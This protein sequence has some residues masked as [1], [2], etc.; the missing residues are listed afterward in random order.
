MPHIATSWLTPAAGAAAA[1][2]HAVH[3]RLP[4]GADAELMSRSLDAAVR[5]WWGGDATER[6]PRLW[7]E[8]VPVDR[9]SGDDRVRAEAGR[10]LHPRDEPFRAVL[11][12]FT[13]GQA[14]LVV[15]AHRERL[16]AESL[17][18]VAAVLTG[19]LS[20]DQVRPATPED[21]GE[22]HGATAEA[23]RAA[24]CAAGLEWATRDGSAGGGTGR[25][26]VE[27]AAGSAD[28]GASLAVAAAIVLAR[29][30]GQDRP[31]LGVL[32]NRRDRP[33]GALGAF[34]TGTLLAPDLSGAVGTADLLA[35]AAQ[36]LDGR[37]GRCGADRYADL[38]RRAGGG[39]TVGVVVAGA[40]A[41]GG[42]EYGDGAE[43][44][45]GAG[46]GEGPERATPYADG[47]AY[48]ACQSAPFP[49]TVVPGRTAAGLPQ[50]IVHHRLDA[51]DAESAARFAR[52]VAF[53]HE[54]LATGGSLA[55]GSVQLLDPEETARTVQLGFSEATL[56][57]TP[58]RIDTVFAARAAERPDAVAVTCEGQ[59][60]TYAELDG[61][62]TR[63]AAALRDG[64][65]VAGDRVGI[66]LDRSLDLVVAMLAVL[67]AD[68][69]YVPMDPAYPADRLAY[70]ARD[71]EL[72]AVV[73]TL[74]TFPRSGGTW[75]VR[76]EELEARGSGP[77]RVPDAAERAPEEAAYVIYTS[78]STGRP[79]GVV[80][81]HRNVV[82]LLAA[83][84]D[85]FGLGPDDTWALFHSSA[86][87]F[88]VWE[89]WGALLTG[90]RLVVV[91][92]WISRE[93]EE[94]HAL[95]RAERVTV[96][97]QTPSAFAQLTAADRRSAERLAVRLVV[98]GGEALDP[99]PLRAWFDRYPEE[100]CRVVNMFGITETTVH[101]TARTVTRREAL[102]GSRSVGRALPGWHLYVLDELRRPVPAGAPGEIYV[103]GEGLALEYLGRPELTRERFVP[104]PFT[105]GRMYRSG[106][107]GRLRPD[108]SLDHLGR[109]DSQVKVRGFRIELD[110]IRT[111]LLEA[112]D[113]VAAA[114]VVE[115]GDSGDAAQARLAAYVVLGPGGDPAEVRRRAQSVLPAHMVPASLTAVPALPLT[116]NGKLDTRKLAGHAER[117]APPVPAAP[118]DRG[119]GLAAGLTSLWEELL[120]VPVAGDDNFF[121]L[122]GNSLLAVRLTAAM[123]ERGMPSL[124]LRELYL[125][126]T[127]TRLTRVLEGS[128]T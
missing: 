4:D 21:P 85:D 100:R 55:P 122:G 74:G 81:P 105:G 12:A 63:W 107:R 45:G 37:G 111:V 32:R 59:A 124:R 89:V 42:A 110:E 127:V 95:L 87:D 66:C 14:E 3:V 69:V 24:E 112:P 73:T 56:A 76:P 23:W 82:A 68:C 80:V 9:A 6:L 31:L 119:T 54:Q 114:V 83:T 123:R 38:V 98:F 2:C 7:C 88:S 27:L 126:P 116:A 71:A 65:A 84:R 40:E 15:V 39:V 108:G 102:S 48:T 57:W 43:G 128:D 109:L 36:A 50:L 101:V 35:G 46:R 51:V 75:W 96:L 93:P 20:H 79:K 103:G 90:A 58:E 118:D 1:R 78:G 26:A 5:A 106:D 13:D 41:G 104:D 117:P 94:F 28:A 44:G 125:N 77:D 53:V 91:P 99:R 19:R 97:N 70:T 22:A 49:L 18:L 25:V 120:G 64:G 121:L 34:D 72:R 47:H 8:R 86:F 33:A 92:F 61:R 29:F 67:K 10:A 115:G 113:V 52:H 30:E 16:D 62:A 17:H 11:L 60:L